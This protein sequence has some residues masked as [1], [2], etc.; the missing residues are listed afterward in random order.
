MLS[1]EDKI[2]RIE[3]IREKKRREKLSKT[4]F[5]PHAE[6]LRLLESKKKDNFVFCGNGWGKTAT[7]AN[8]AIWMADGFNPITKQY[9][10][11]PTNVHI[12]LDHPSKVQET[13]LPEMRKWFH[14]EEKDCYKNGKP[15]Y[16]EIRRR[17]GSRIVFMFHE[18]PELVFESTEF[19]IIIFDEPPP[20]H[21][22]IAMKRGQRT[23]GFDHRVYC[24][25]TPLYQQWLREEIYERWT[26]D[27]LPDTECYFGN[28]D[29]NKDNFPEGYLEEF[30]RYMTPEE[31]DVRLRGMFFS[32]GSLALRHLW[33][34]DVHIITRDQFEALWRPAFPCV[35]AIDPHP[36]K[37]HHVCLLGAG[38]DGR[39]YYIKEFAAKL[40]AR[41]FAKALREFMNGYR[42]V[43]II[44]DSLGSAEGTGNDDFKSFIDVLREN[45]IPCR[46]TSYK[47]K[48]DEDFVE[49][50]KTN[51]AIPVEPDNFGF[52]VPN[53]RV[54]EG[55]DGII[56]DIENVQWQRDKV[57]RINKPKLDITQRDFL[58][59]LKYGLATGISHRHS[60]N[61]VSS[62]GNTKKPLY[63][64][65]KRGR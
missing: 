21:I 5:K 37:Q 30:S 51:I 49:K 12:I 58:A 48:S 17:N 8:L 15:F 22:F 20:R 57:A 41:E 60:G 25:G 19:K 1:K 34:R 39:L 50:I 9:Y 4:K 45:G 44:V 14:I 24:L 59:T 35:V 10:K 18:Q 61:K 43:D 2:K 52:Y 29:A 33:K 16:N 38:R 32:S 56:K 64:F 26:K 55:N 42:V 54:V 3:L 31:K 11:V 47:E 63:G 40:V 65:N 13:W 7:G 23:K 28:S 27:E 36:S 62:I 46:A 53:L 6:Q